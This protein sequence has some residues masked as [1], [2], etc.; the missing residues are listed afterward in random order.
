MTLAS[1]SKSSKE[2]R[3]NAVSEVRRRRQPPRLEADLSMS[4]RDK[5]EGKL[6][7]TTQN[8]NPPAVEKQLAFNRSSPC[9]TSVRHSISLKRLSKQALEAKRNSCRQMLMSKLSIQTTTSVPNL[10][11]GQEPEVSSFAF[12]KIG[13]LTPHTNL[14]EE[15]QAM[16]CRTPRILRVSPRY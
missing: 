6:G 4:K 12:I 8:P 15:K 1:F 7:L 9:K 5:S 3:V 10:W 2:G 13:S 14:W 11:P 16:A